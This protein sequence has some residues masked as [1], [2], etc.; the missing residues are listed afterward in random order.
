MKSMYFY[1]WASKKFEVYLLS[2]RINNKNLSIK[3]SLS[4]DF[5]RC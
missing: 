3:T 2:K 1:L 4:S 5:K